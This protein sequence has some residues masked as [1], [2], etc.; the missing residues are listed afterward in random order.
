MFGDPGDIYQDETGAFWFKASGV[1]TNT[2][3]TASGGGGAGGVMALPEQW[4]VESI[5]ANQAATAMSAQVSTN[6][7]TT[8]AIRA[9]SIVGLATRLVAAITAGQLD[10]EVT[11]NGV[12]TGFLIVH[13]AGSNPSGGVATQAVGV[14]TYVAGDL[15]GIQY[16]T[17]IGFLPLLNNIEAWLE[18]VEAI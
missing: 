11:I 8:K 12:G 9:G 4:A 7:D 10:V 14:D 1:A 3:W 18:V 15:I 17:D 6:F 13:T 5:P 16:T 2:G